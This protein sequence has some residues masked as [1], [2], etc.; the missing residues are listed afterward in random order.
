MAHMECTAAVDCQAA[1]RARPEHREITRGPV[2]SSASANCAHLWV[3]L[4][5]RA[6][7][8]RLHPAAHS[9]APRA[10]A[11]F[12]DQFLIVSCSVSSELCSVSGSPILTEIQL[13][14]DGLADC[15]QLRSHRLLGTSRADIVP[16]FFQPKQQA[17]YE[18]IWTE[19]VPNPP[20]HP[21]HSPLVRPG[22]RRPGVVWGQ[23]PGR[24]S[25]RTSLLSTVGVDGLATSR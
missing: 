4:F 18:E 5:H 2:T 17:H 3:Q 13:T 8:T 11:A 24:A 10:N 14:A 23:G 16:D 12:P 15:A 1:A 6:Q 25:R 22:R 19:D 20:D 9:P 21:R 7:I